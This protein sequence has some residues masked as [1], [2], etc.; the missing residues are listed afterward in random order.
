MKSFVRFYMDRWWMPV[1]IFAAYLMIAT[2]PPLDPW[3][4]TFVSLFMR[5]IGYAAFCGM[6]VAGTIN[7]TRKR[8]LFGIVNLIIPL[9]LLLMMIFP[10]LAFV[11][12]CIL[13]RLAESV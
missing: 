10:M 12:Y 6:T 9:F 13:M 1:G 3:N 4:T 11:V 5:T 7:L 2:L 8:W